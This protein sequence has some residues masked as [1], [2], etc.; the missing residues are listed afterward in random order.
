METGTSKLTV[1]KEGACGLLLFNNPERRNA[2]DSEM[3]TALP[4]T[5]KMFADDPKIRVVVVAGAGEKAFI[6]GADTSQF[7]KERQDADAG[8]RYDEMS[9]AAFQAI[10]SCPKPTIARI[11]GFCIGAGVAVAMCCDLRVASEDAA[12]AI[13]PGRLGLSYPHGSLKRLI[14]VIGPAHTKELLFTA[15]HFTAA[16]AHPMGLI[17]Q[18]VARENLESTVQKLCDTIAANAPLSLKAAKYM[19]NEYC[20]RGDRIDLQMFQKLA[21]DRYESSDYTEGRRAA[22]EKRA[23]VFEGR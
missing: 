9:N 4:G 7:A 16:E 8:A 20:A 13:P 23:P 5:M 14:D 6:S 22:A 12:F 21:R 17:S 1:H 11:H 10:V 19:I 18:V 2:I 3:W 15:R